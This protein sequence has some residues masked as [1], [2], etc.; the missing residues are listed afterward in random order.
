MSRYSLS[1]PGVS[2]ATELVKAM[3]RYVTTEPVYVATELASARRISV[4]RE[5]F[6]RDRAGHDRKFCRP[7]KSRAS[8][9]QRVRQC[10]RQAPSARG[11]GHVTGPRHAMTAPKARARPCRG[12]FCRNRLV[13]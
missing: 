2:V 11:S 6:Y 3:G 9:G 7:Q 13:Q 1:R 8:E 10:A 4:D 5:F 12:T